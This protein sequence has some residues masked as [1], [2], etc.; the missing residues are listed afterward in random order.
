MQWPDRKGAAPAV[1]KKFSKYFAWQAIEYMANATPKEKLTMRTTNVS[2]EIVCAL[3]AVVAGMF[4]TFAAPAAHAGPF[5]NVVPSVTTET[6]YLWNG[7]YIAFNSGAVWTNFN[8]GDYTTK[9][10]LT[11]QFNEALG[12]VPQTGTS[13]PASTETNLLFF[14]VDSHEST[15][16]AY[17][18]GV[19]LGY[20]FVFGG[21]F[22][23]GPVI[24]FSGTRTT[25]GSL[26]RDFAINHPI[27]A[28][29]N[30]GAEA[31]SASTE[32]NTSRH[33]EQDWSG[34]AGA[35]IG[36]AWRRFLFYAT[37]G[38]AFSQIDM[39]T[40]DQAKTLFFDAAG[41]QMFPLEREGVVNATN[42]VLTG[43]Y[44]GGGMQFAFSDALRAG[45]EYRHSDY[46][47]R[48]YHF[49]H[50]TGEAVFPGATRVDVNNNAVV[51]KVSIML[52]HLAKTA[53]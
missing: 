43:W 47:D 25:N 32:F 15:A 44:A 51:F 24:G 52:G 14:D 17:I 26:E 39:R 8:I 33:A 37:G 19:D 35:Q 5:K 9:I 31:T 21:H 38:S 12:A 40:F 48:L 30:P 22:V 42:N 34:Y 29:S 7:P 20:N 6:E 11:R 50:S 18:G 28:F 41:A 23:I 2:R 27:F 3:S 49:F 13:P 53:K 36:F 45:I 16:G 10:D 46:G 4:L 1:G